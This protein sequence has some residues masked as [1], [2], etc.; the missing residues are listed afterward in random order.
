MNGCCCALHMFAAMFQSNHSLGHVPDRFIDCY[1]VTFLQA[2][3]MFCCPVYSVKA[4]KALHT[5]HLVFITINMC[6]YHL[7]FFVKGGK[8]LQIF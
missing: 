1:S 5:L 6:V 7:F 3:W 4:L 8:L 2:N